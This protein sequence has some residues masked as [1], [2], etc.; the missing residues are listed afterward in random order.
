V[1]SRSRPNWHNHKA[2]R[3]GLREVPCGMHLS[4]PFQTPPPP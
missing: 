3:S 4:L 1:E 2:S